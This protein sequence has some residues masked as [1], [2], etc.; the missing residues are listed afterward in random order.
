V[1]VRVLV[2]TNMDLDKAVKEG[3]FREDLYYRLNVVRITIPPLRERSDEI[4]MFTEHFLK[5][6]SRRHG[7][8]AHKI[9]SDL[10]DLF[11]TYSWPGNVRE[12]ENATQRLLILGDEAPIIQE[13]R[14]FEANDLPLVEEDKDKGEK[15]MSGEAISLK[16]VAR[17]ASEDVERKAI[18]AAL[19][20]TNW[21]RK[22]AA[23][24]LKIS[25]KGLLYK[26]N[27]LGL[28]R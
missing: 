23:N 3:K 2:A 1:D 16:M 13:L 22:K 5:L 14:L 17:K 27:R 7:G 21:N 11:M 10:M 24:L 19:A 25:Y 6:F 12:L 28:S 20:H 26:I 4:P 8:K 18:L 15:D 9:S